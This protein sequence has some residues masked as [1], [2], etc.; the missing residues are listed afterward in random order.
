MK[1][2]LTYHQQK[3]RDDHVLHVLFLQTIMSVNNVD[4]VVLNK[5]G[6]A[7]REAAVSGLTKEVFYKNHFK[8]KVKTT[9]NNNKK[10]S[11]IVVI[12]RIRGISTERT[13]KQEKK[14]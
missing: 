5:R 13:L 3:G 7:L 1:I 8:S 2:K 10:K 12:H 4:L 9:S 11:K 6:E 14:S